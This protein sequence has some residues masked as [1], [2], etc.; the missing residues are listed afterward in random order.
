M[1]PTHFES[2]RSEM[3]DLGVGS[4]VEMA[5]VRDKTHAVA[6]RVEIGQKLGLATQRCL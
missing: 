2:L 1:S 5:L 4:L 6:Q 3:S